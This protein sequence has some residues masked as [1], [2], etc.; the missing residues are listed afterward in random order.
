MT[1]I[2]LPDQAFWAGGD[3]RIGD[4]ILLVDCDTRVPLDCMLPVVSELLRSPHVGFTQ[5]FTTPLQA[6]PPLCS[7]FAC[8]APAFQP[9]AFGLNARTHGNFI[10]CHMCQTRA[11]FFS[12][13]ALSSYRHTECRKPMPQSASVA[14]VAASREGIPLYEVHAGCRWRMTTSRTQWPSSPTPSTTPSWSPSP[15]ATFH[16]W[17]A[18]TPSCAGAPSRRYM[19]ACQSPL[20]QCT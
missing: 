11:S 13:V 14:E 17:W 18:T 5:H 12:C 7:C 9:T 16:P 6:C 10:P 20:A 2:A 8:C 19:T 3:V 1:G 15:G 4:F